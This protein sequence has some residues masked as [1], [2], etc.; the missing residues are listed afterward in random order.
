MKNKKKSLFYK[1][2]ILFLILLLVIVAFIFY[3][4]I[5]PVSFENMVT[6]ST[7]LSEGF[8]T[9]NFI[10]NNLSN[11]ESGIFTNYEDSSSQDVDTKG[12]SVLSESQ[13]LMMIHG[14]N[15]NNQDIFDRSFNYVKKNMI[16]NNNLISWRT[17][18]NDK[19]PSSAFIDDIRIAK[20]LCLG[21]E[22]FNKFSYRYESQKLSKSLLE[23]SLIDYVPSD[24]RDNFGTSKTFT[25]CYGDLQGMNMLSYYDKDWMKVKENTKS[26]LENGK[27]PNSIFFKKS[28][29]ISTK[30]YSTENEVELLYSLMVWESLSDDGEDISPII[31]FIKNEISSN[32]YL[33]T[34][35]SFNGIVTEKVESTSIYAIA[36]RLSD[37]YGDGELSTKL[38]TKLLNY[39]IKNGELEGGFGMEPT[40]QFYSFDNLQALLSLVESK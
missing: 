8:K 18:N 19:N 39:Q 6:N 28:Y 38:R 25:L 5:K 13:G 21:Y 34:K 3:P 36:L 26:I 11:D 24:F 27:I 14:V 30:T 37:K 40:E 17:E 12:H 4:Y 10:Y 7:L 15:I 1:L 20:A 35:Y 31:E 33:C 32:G 2:I 29:D 16:L 22:K 23:N 9:E